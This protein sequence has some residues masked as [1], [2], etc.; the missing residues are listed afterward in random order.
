[1]IRPIRPDPPPALRHTRRH[2]T[3]PQGG[4]GRRRLSR[5]TPRARLAA[6]TLL[7][8]RDFASGEL[9]GQTAAGRLSGRGRR[10]R[11]CGPDGAAIL[12]DARF[13]AQYVA[14]HAQRGQGPRRIAMDLASRGVA[15]PHDR[16]RPGRR[17]GLG[18]PGARGPQ[19]AVRA[20]RARILGREGQTGTF[21]AVPGLFIGSYPVGPGPRF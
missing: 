14:Y 1:M 2:E 21:F 11:H 4:F 8:R 15:P 18:R 20:H 12:D 7:A 6:V 17:S 19:P 9:A 5:L 13:A 16:G 10:G 3:P